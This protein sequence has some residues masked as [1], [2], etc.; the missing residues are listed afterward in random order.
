MLPADQEIISSHLAAGV[1]QGVPQ[2]SGIVIEWT[3]PY[4]NGATIGVST[5]TST[6]YPAGLPAYELVVDEGSPTM[7]D[8]RPCDTALDPNCEATYALSV[9]Q[10]VYA[11]FFLSGT[12]HTFKVR[13]ANAN[14]F[15]EW[16]SF[17]NFGTSPN[18]PLKPPAPTA[19]CVDDP[20]QTCGGSI[21]ITATKPSWN[22]GS[23][24][25]GW[26]WNSIEGPSPAQTGF[27]RCCDGSDGGSPGTAGYPT[28]SGSIACPA[29]EYEITGVSRATDKNFI[30][31]VAALN[32]YGIGEYSFSLAIAVDPDAP[33]SPENLV[34]DQSSVT[35]QKFAIDFDV[36]GANTSNITVFIKMRPYGL[37]TASYDIC[38]NSNADPFV[39]Q[40]Y[41]SVSRGT[42][43]FTCAYNDPA[44]GTQRCRYLVDSGQFTTTPTCNIPACAGQGAPP[45]PHHHHHHHHQP[46]PAL[47]CRLCSA[48]FLIW[49]A[50]RR[51]SRSM[52]STT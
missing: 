48:P 7:V 47:P 23:P 40:Q 2:S 27:C 26:C 51:T 11:L 8:G 42:P 38:A 49:Q 39:C 13:A 28:C 34:V 30:I 41:I 44:P 24:V 10:T 32:A 22:G 36:P 29:D 37:G 31:S 5:P 19:A 33:D 46:C 15:G 21:T 50:S 43:D 52:P 6:T 20:T 14:G 18:V 3:P 9:D 4:D 45:P 25:T 1:V 35:G 12:N 17:A 16:S